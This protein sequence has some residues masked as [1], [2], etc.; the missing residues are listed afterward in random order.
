MNHINTIHKFTKEINE[1]FIFEDGPKIAIAVS[2]GPDSLALAI[3]SNQWICTIGGTIVCLTV[4]HNL[5]SE[6]Y[7]EALMVKSICEQHKIEHHILNW[8]GTE[9]LSNIQS[10]ARDARRHLLT[11]WCQNHHI[12]YL[13]L[14]HTQDDLVETFFMR[15]LRGSGTQGLSSISALS[16]F[17]TISI[18]RPLLNFKKRELEQYLTQQHVNWAKDPSNFNTKFLRTK[19]RN[20]LK[21][22]EMQDIIEYDLM[23]DRCTKGINSIQSVNTLVEEQ[24]N[25]ILSEIVLMHPEGYI[26]IELG[27]FINLPKELALNILASCLMTIS[28]KHFY[29]PRFHSLQNLYKKLASGEEKATTLWSCEIK[30]KKD[31]IY[32]Y[33]EE[34]NTHNKISIINK[35]CIKWDDRFVIKYENISHN[36]KIQK[37]TSISLKDLKHFIDIKKYQSLP[38]KIFY[39]LPI[40]EIKGTLYVPFL[41]KHP[42]PEINIYFEPSIPLAKTIFNY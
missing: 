30:I 29:R 27:Y 40:I 1:N 33:F 28:G 22:K 3:L 34:Q 26:T 7:E 25:K 10:K 41:T 2:G 36:T 17:N 42:I 37:L 21:S 13:F 32:I 6:A 31:L 11:T 35:D 15:L 5:R 39:S 14:A 8:Q 16:H 20:L 19:I 9:D 38:K 18:I 24:K 23:L 12:K 4:N